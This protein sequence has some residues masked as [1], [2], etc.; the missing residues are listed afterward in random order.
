MRRIFSHPIL[1]LAAG[2]CLRLFLV[3]KFPGE[4]GD[5]P[6]YEEIAGN[7]LKEHAY[8]TGAHGALT[9]VDVRMPGYPAFLAAMYA[10]TGR[11]GESARLW[12]MIAQAGIDLISCCVIAGLGCLLAAGV[13]GKI[14]NKRV[15]TAG[16]WLAA[17]CPF[18]ANYVAVPLTEVFVVLLTAV[19]LSFFVLQFLRL[20]QSEIL[21]GRY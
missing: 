15:F 3:L 13:S 8:A 7:W 19:A 5:T 4:S 18:T 10:I 2:L 14:D 11:T 17:L 16:L 1:A 20:K 9:P 12:V 6:L 21:F